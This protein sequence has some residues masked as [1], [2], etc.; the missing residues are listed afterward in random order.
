MLSGDPN[1]KVRLAARHMIA[2]LEAVEQYKAWIEKESGI[3]RRTIIRPFRVPLLDF[4]ATH[5]A[6][7]VKLKWKLMKG[8]GSPPKQPFFPVF[9][10]NSKSAIQHEPVTMPPII[11]QMTRE[12]IDAIVDTPLQADFPCPSQ[13]VEHGVATTTQCV[14]RRR[15]ESTQLTCV[16]QTVEAR[17][18]QPHV[19]THKRYRKDY[20]NISKTVK[21]Q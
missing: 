8:P 18:Q 17:A 15:K 12:Q 19:V 3:K 1:V 16:L 14:K 9:M 20:V 10:L 5:Y 21:K 2:K 13:T 6:K 4:T 11:K 7:M